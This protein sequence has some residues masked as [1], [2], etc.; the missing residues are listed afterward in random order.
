MSSDDKMPTT[1]PITYASGSNW[2]TAKLDKTIAPTTLTLTA[3]AGTLAS[4]SYT[5]TVTVAAPSAGNTPQTITVTL[6]VLSSNQTTTLSAA[7]QSTVFLDSPNLGTQLTVQSGSQF[8]IV[9][10]N[11]AAT[12]S[13]TEDFRLAGALIAYMLA[14]QEATA[15][16]NRES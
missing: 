2:L 12:A 1:G 7:G 4:G 13:V 10:V 6:L 15:I 11:T 16:Q 5:A 14:D 3:N 9:V 8:L